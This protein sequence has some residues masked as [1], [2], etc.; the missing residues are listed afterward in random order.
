MAWM[1]HQSLG[2]SPRNSQAWGG[3]HWHGVGTAAQSGL[4]APSPDTST[5]AVGPEPFTPGNCETS[6]LD[7]VTWSCT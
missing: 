1:T 6:T 2:S 5:P 3:G 7:R 4:R